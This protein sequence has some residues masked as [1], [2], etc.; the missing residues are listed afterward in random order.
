MIFRKNIRKNSFVTFQKGGG[1]WGVWRENLSWELSEEFW[2]KISVNFLKEFLYIYCSYFSRKFHNGVWKQGVNSL[3][4]FEWKVFR[5]KN[6]LW[7]FRS[8]P[9]GNCSQVSAEG[10]KSI[11][12]IISVRFP[13]KNP[14]AISRTIK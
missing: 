3:R 10:F 4:K 1:G 2:E 14:E 11:L 12:E 9:R 7:Y 6:R 8:D 13:K 5:R